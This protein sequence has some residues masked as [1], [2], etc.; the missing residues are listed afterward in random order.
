WATSCTKWGA[1]RGSSPCTLTMIVL[2]G[3]VFFGHNFRQPVRAGGV[4]W[5]RE[6]RFAAKV[7]DHLLNA[8]VVGG[9]PN[10]IGARTIGVLNDSLNHWLAANVQ[11]RLSGEAAGSVARG[12]DDSETSHSAIISSSK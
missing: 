9:H 6:D 3:T 4:Q 1:R 10:E 5:R 11:Q 7:V 8:F 2:S 12:D